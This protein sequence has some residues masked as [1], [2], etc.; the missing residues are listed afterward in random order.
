MCEEYSY[1]AGGYKKSFKES[2]CVA[3]DVILESAR[4]HWTSGLLLYNN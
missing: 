2:R 4:I 3:F 1:S